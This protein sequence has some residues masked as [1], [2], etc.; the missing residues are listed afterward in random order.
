MRDP[1]ANN[2]CLDTNDCQCD[3]CQGQLA[4]WLAEEEGK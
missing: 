4:S 1:I 2:S 3:R